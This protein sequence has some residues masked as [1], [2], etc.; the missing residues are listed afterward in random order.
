MGGLYHAQ[1]QKVLSE[2]FQ[3][4]K[5]FFSFLVEGEGE[6]GSKYH[7]KQSIIGPPEKRNL[8]GVSLACR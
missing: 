1:I 3:L 7:Y 8:N 4:R 2:G 5:L 6:R